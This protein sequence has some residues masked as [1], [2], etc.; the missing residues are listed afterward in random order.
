MIWIQIHSASLANGKIVECKSVKFGDF[1]KFGEFG[2]L[3][4]SYVIY[5]FQL[6]YILNVGQMVK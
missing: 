4:V 6:K 1:G 2:Q 5:I 3:Y